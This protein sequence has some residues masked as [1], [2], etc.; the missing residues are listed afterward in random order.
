MVGFV[1]GVATY[2][3]CE[4]FCPGDLGPVGTAVAGGIF[5]G[6]LGALVGLL[7][8]NF[9][10]VDHWVDVPLQRLRV[11]LGQQRDGR[12]GFGASVRF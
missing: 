5:A 9:V 2:E 7:V 4:G 6:G 10:T 1:I 12:F 3:G 11:S 8:G